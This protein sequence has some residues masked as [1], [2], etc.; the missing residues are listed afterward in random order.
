MHEPCPATHDNVTKGPKRHK[1]QSQPEASVTGD[2]QQAKRLSSMAADRIAAYRVILA[3]SNNNGT[4]NVNGKVMLT[5]D[6]GQ[7]IQN[8]KG[9]RKA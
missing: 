3:K 2:R 9:L 5:L 1:Q 7:R 8:L 6:I 4:Y